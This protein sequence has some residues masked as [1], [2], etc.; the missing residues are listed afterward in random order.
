MSHAALLSVLSHLAVLSI[1]LL[2]YKQHFE[3]FTEILSNFC[4]ISSRMSS[5]NKM[6]L[7]KQSGKAYLSSA[8]IDLNTEWGI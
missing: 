4:L 3:F 8:S 6:V 5:R 7:S 2:V 1:D